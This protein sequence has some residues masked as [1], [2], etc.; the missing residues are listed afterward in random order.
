MHVMELLYIDKTTN[1]QRSLYIYISTLP[2][3]LCFDCVAAYLPLYLDV[4]GTLYVYARWSCMRIGIG[5]ATSLRGREAAF[6]FWLMWNGWCSWARAHT[7]T[8]RTNTHWWNPL[9]Y[10]AKLIAANDL[11]LCA[12][13]RR[14][15]QSRCSHIQAILCVS[16]LSLLSEINEILVAPRLAA[17]LPFRSRTTHFVI[18]WFVGYS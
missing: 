11:S 12:V 18:R 5:I 8:N 9:Q 17:L 6:E 13:D 2:S 3:S 14:N 10:W 1:N 16:A 4:L 7:K 15:S